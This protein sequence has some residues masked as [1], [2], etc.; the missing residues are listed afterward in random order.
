MNLL[1]VCVLFVG[2]VF[3]IL[4]FHLF[5]IFERFNIKNGLRVTPRIHGSQRDV[6]TPT[7]QPSREIF[8]AKPRTEHLI[9]HIINT[10]THTHMKTRTLHMTQEKQ[11][12]HLLPPSLAGATRVKYYCEYVFESS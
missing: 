2:A 4:I 11:Q 10:H 6:R 5:N 7:D 8:L 12:Q 9:T 1:C 3:I